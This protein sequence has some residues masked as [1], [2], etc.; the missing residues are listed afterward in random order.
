MRLLT[1]RSQNHT[2]YFLMSKSSSG[3]QQRHG[4]PVVKA[5]A[6]DS[7]RAVMPVEPLFRS[8]FDVLPLQAAD[9]LAWMVRQRKSAESDEFPFSWLDEELS[10]VKRSRLSTT[11]G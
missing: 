6:E 5:F 4:Y 10:G 3:R 11:L 9:L 8:D 1:W 2:R 7:I